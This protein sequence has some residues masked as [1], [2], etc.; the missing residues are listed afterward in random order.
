MVWGSEYRGS[1]R[2]CLKLSIFGNKFLRS[3][4]YDTAGKDENIQVSN[5]LHN[6]L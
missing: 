2:A 3:L 1:L 6:L 4:A 5:A